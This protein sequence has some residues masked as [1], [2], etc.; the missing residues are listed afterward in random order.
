MSSISVGAPW[1]TCAERQFKEYAISSL[2]SPSAL[3]R[4]GT[5]ANRAVKIRGQVGLGFSQ[6]S[7]FTAFS[8]DLISN[9]RARKKRK[10]RIRGASGFRKTVL[11]GAGEIAYF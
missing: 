10:E 2:Y 6:Y 3:R 8:S 4:A 9:F 7:V 5:Q 1:Q 11:P